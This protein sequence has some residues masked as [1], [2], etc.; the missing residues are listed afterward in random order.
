MTVR[1]AGVVPVVDDD[2]AGDDDLAGV[3]DGVPLELAELVVDE[4]AVALVD[5]GGAGGVLEEEHAPTLSSATAAVTTAPER[6]PGIPPVV[7]AP[8]S[9]GPS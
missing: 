8:L 1:P 2:V 5:A 3:A 4:A 7:L 9:M 6:P